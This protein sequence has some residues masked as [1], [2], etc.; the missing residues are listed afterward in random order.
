MADLGI[1]LIIFGVLFWIFSPLSEHYDER[2]C[3]VMILLGLVLA[4]L[5]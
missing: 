5:M 4:T 1:G 3:I 2:F